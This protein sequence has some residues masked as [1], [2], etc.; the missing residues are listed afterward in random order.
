MDVVIYG[1]LCAEGGEH[2]AAYRLL[3][4]ALFREFGMDTVPDIARESGGKPFFPDFPEL[5]FNISHSHGAAVV[6]L[7]DNSIGIDVEKLRPAPKRLSAGKADEEFFRSWTAQ[8]A[9]VKRRGG[10]IAAVL[11]GRIEIDPLCRVYDDILP[12]YFVSVCPS[13]DAPVRIEKAGEGRL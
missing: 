5:H 2:D 6:V 7:H 9:T 12:G 8:E 10:S 13:S 11:R 3:K 1:T 4:E